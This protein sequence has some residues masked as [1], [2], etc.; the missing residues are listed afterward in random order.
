M[1]LALFR[2][3]Q[4]GGA[5]ANLP[6]WIFRVA[7]NLALKQRTRQQRMLERTR[8]LSIAGAVADPLSDA[9]GHLISA[10]RRLR[11]A[12]VLRALPPR[13][14]H[15]MHLYTEG[16]RY[17]DIARALGISLGAV[18]KSLARTVARLQRAHGRQ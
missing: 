14:R 6:G 2:H 1:F 5:R 11:S 10:E 7:H 18:S 12:A 8:S 16:L 4:R 9:E 13:N 17:R 3:L 15:C